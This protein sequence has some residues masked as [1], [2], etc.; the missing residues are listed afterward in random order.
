[1]KKK[2]FKHYVSV[3]WDKDAYDHFP[4]PIDH[5]CQT[6]FGSAYFPFKET[7]DRGKIDMTNGVWQS[8]LRYKPFGIDYAFKH[9]RDAD[10]FKEE[11]NLHILQI[12]CNDTNE[13]VDWLDKM[14]GGR[15]PGKSY[16]RDITVAE[17]WATW[18]ADCGNQMLHLWGKIDRSIKLELMLRYG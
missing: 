3:D 18:I 10:L 12:R 5:L 2:I 7:I 13:A 17:N 16:R 15:L 11:L 9:K 14:V 8:G 1:M 4:H 6:L